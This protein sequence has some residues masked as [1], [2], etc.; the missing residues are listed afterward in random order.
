MAGCHPPLHL[1]SLLCAFALRTDVC[2]TAVALCLRGSAVHCRVFSPLLL[3]HLS[4]L[5]CGPASLVCRLG[6]WSSFPRV[7][8]IRPFF[9]PSVRC[10]VSLLLL[11]LQKD[12]TR[13]S[14]RLSLISSSSSHPYMGAPLLLVNLRSLCP[15]F[16]HLVPTVARRVVLALPSQVPG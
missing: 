8:E 1:S 13:P 3:L 11:C 10:M 16:S 15:L 5:Q 12:I 6:T 2:R 14:R 4:V 9:R 7:V